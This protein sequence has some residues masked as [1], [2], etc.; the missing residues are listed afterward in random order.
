MQ[1]ISMNNDLI[2]V[3]RQKV[4]KS[5]PGFLANRKWTG[6]PDYPIEISSDG[7]VLSIYFTT[8]PE[9][10]QLKAFLPSYLQVY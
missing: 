10:L 4:W 6:D 2:P 7:P 9:S 8:G 5:W 3:Q 1:T